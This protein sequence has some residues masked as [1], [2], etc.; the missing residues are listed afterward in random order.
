MPSTIIHHDITAGNIQTPTFLSQEDEFR[1]NI[2]IN[3]YIFTLT[4]NAYVASMVF[5]NRNRGD[6]TSNK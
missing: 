6:K 4:T 3:R 5:S 2:D 1:I